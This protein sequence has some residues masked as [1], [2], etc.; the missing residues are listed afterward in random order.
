[1]ISGILTRIS[2][3]GAADWLRSTAWQDIA[4][5]ACVM[6]A[7]GVVARRF[8]PRRKVCASRAE[9]SVTARSSTPCGGCSGCGLSSAPSANPVVVA[10]GGSSSSADAE[11]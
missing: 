11:T 5:S 4:S 6:L 2:E 3:V 8:F 10:L 9:Q 7:C 1:M